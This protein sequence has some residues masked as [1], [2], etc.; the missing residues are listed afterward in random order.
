[1]KNRSRRYDINKTRQRQGHKYT[2]DKMRLGIIMLTCI[3]P[4]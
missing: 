2:K 4:F 1:M 3:S